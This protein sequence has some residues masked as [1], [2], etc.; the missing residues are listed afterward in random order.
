MNY[1][2]LDIDGVLNDGSYLLLKQDEDGAI[3]EKIVELFAMLVKQFDA[4]VILCSNWRH[5]FTDSMEPR[6]WTTRYFDGTE[7]DSRCAKLF[8]M[9]NKYGIKLCGK[10][11]E[12]FVNRPDAVLAYVQENLEAEDKYIIIDDDFGECYSEVM[13]EVAP[14]LVQPDFNKGF[15]EKTFV[16]AVTVLQ[17]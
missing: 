2:F 16:K 6:V 14:H 7:E 11:S 12:A 17:K 1:I 13:A 10:T 8:K 9:L 4:K 15:D 5:G 3:D